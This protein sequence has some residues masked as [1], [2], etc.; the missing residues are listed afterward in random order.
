MNENAEQN[1]VENIP[2][3]DNLHQYY[4]VDIDDEIWEAIVKH[5]DTVGI[6]QFA[7]ELEMSAYSIKG[8]ITKKTRRITPWN[9]LKL[10][11]IINIKR[12]FVVAERKENSLEMT[13]SVENGSIQMCI[14]GEPLEN[15]KSVEKISFS[16][17][18]RISYELIG[19]SY[20]SDNAIIG[21]VQNLYEKAVSELQGISYAI[22]Y[23]GKLTDTEIALLLK[24]LENNYHFREQWPIKEIY[25]FFYD[26]IKS[27]T[28]TE[29]WRTKVIEFLQQISCEKKVI[30]LQ[31]DDVPVD[32]YCSGMLVM[33]T[34]TFSN[35]MS[36][37][38]VLKLVEEIGGEP[39]T[40]N[41]FTSDVSILI[42]GEKGSEAWRFSGYGRKLEAAIQSRE[43]TGFP[44]IVK[45]SDFLAKIG[46]K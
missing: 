41:K 7:E 23:D 20:S 2:V 42:V 30:T 44:F 3:P 12:D 18:L 36:R 43:K 38:E 35:G 24:W 28:I 31:F 19:E 10:S 21:N 16:E 37:A 26:L 11:K 34:G 15:K 33:V 1:N 8:W 25:N 29:E 46:K 5:A 27:S 40:G 22:G 32:A 4:N 14:N 9:W 6:K 45:E 13:I 39:A 17:M